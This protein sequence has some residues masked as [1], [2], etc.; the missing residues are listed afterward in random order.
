MV[1]KWGPRF[2][3]LNLKLSIVIERR[4]KRSDRPEPV[5]PTIPI[6]SFGR[7]VQETFFSTRGRLSLYLIS[8]PSNTI[9]PSWGQSDGGALFFTLAGASRDRDWD[10]ERGIS[11][12]HP[13]RSQFIVKNDKLWSEILNVKLKLS[14]KKMMQD[15]DVMMD[16]LYWGE[17]SL[18]LRRQANSK[19]E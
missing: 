8:V 9:S 14:V 18:G 17:P 12:L 15:L 2:K 5:R 1:Y 6:F 3:K 4:H 7:M 10:R 11:K 19:L 13:L 16:S